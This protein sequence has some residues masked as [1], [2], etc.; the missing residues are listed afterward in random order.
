MHRLL[1]L[2]LSVLS[3]SFLSLTSANAAVFIKIGDIKGESVVKDHVEEIEV[4]SWS[5]GVERPIT[6]GDGST[7]TRGTPQVLDLEI[8]KILERSTPKLF[9]ACVKGTVLPE[10]V[11]VIRKPDV[12]AGLLKTLEIRLTNV[13]VTSDT[14]TGSTDAIEKVTL[15]FETIAMTYFIL[16]SDGTP[17]GTVEM[18]Y[19]LETGS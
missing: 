10:A 11:L 4:L 6:S 14:L 15:D 7:R 13:S 12:D 1:F 9:E 3:I 8:S 2:T 18:S 16:N 5:W 19:N 17:G